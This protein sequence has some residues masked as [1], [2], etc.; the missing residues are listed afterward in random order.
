MG[1]ERG[2]KRGPRC[3]FGQRMFLAQPDDDMLGPTVDFHHQGKLVGLFGFGGLAVL[4]VD[5]GPVG[6]DVAPGAPE[7]GRVIVFES[8]EGGQEAGLDI[9]SHAIADYGSRR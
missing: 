7:N 2:G 9:E 8:C 1:R 4:L 6:P 3:R 5:A